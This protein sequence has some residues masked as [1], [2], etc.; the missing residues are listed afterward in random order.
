MREAAEGTDLQRGVVV[1][2]FELVCQREHGGQLGVVEFMVVMAVMMMMKM[3]V[4]MVMM[5]GDGGD[6]D[7]VN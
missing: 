6:N 4:V 2:L 3:V 5:F 1:A 7:G